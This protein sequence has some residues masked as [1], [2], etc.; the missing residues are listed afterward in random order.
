[1]N[2]RAKSAIG[3]LLMT[4]FVIVAVFGFVE[5]TQDGGCIASMAQNG[6]VCPPNAGSLEVTAFHLNAFKIFT[7]ANFKLGVMLLSVLLFSLVLNF[8]L[9]KSLVYSLVEIFSV[10]STLFQ[11]QFSNFKSLLRQWLSFH[12]NSPN[13]V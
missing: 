8:F 12:T 13:L 2:I 5:I 4:S 10:R 6:A 3:L 7:S 9:K 11:I 1:M